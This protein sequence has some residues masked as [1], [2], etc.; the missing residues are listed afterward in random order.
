MNAA[1]STPGRTLIIACGNPLRGDDGIAW[2]AAEQL[3]AFSGRQTQIICVHQLLPELAEDV[4]HADVVVFL[5]ASREGTPGDISCGPASNPAASW[6]F[7]HQ[8]VPS[9]VLDLCG[10]LYG[11]RPKALLIKVHGADF[12]HKDSLSAIAA[13]ALPQVVN[14][15]LE[16]TGR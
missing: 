2:R 15:V 12:S 1:S 3:R 5:D 4:S 7:S 8:M 10:R 9:H 13:K 6:R 11:K 14:A 16:A